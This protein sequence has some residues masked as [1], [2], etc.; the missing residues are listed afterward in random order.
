MNVRLSKGLTLIEVM[1][2]LMILA[3]LAA[4]TIPNVLRHKI[5][6]NDTMAK[7]TLKTIAVALESYF[8]DNSQYPAVTDELMTA[9]P[10]Y[11]GTDYFEGSHNGFTFTADYLTDQTYSV[12]AAPIGPN[13]G[14][15]S[16]TITQ[17]GVFTEN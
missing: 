13:F 6:A 2:V 9:D 10:V 12:T 3:I 4:I 11:I 5:T 1:I 8:I 15:A 16:F 14:S 17:G 7:A